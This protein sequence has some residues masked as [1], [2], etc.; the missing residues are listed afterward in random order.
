MK[1]EKVYGEVGGCRGQGVGGRVFRGF[2]CQKVRSIFGFGSTAA[3]N[4]KRVH[5][6][7]TPCA[8]GNNAWTSG[9]EVRFSSLLFFSV[10]SAVGEAVVEWQ[11][12]KVN[13]NR[14]QANSRMEERT[15]TEK[16]SDKTS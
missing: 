5:A 15:A 8:T 16:E 10:T 11:A 14:P 6:L 1:E 13:I 2:A 4:F 9:N 12:F 3:G 7:S